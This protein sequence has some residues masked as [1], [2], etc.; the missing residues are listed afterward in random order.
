[1]PAGHRLVPARLLGAVEHAVHVGDINRVVVVHDDLADPAARQ[2]LHH[3]DADAA[4]ADDGDAEVAYALVVFDHPHGL[5]RHEPR[6]WLRTRS[7]GGGGPGGHGARGTGGEARTLVSVA[8]ALMTSIFW[9]R[10]LRGPVVLEY[11]R[12]T[13]WISFTWF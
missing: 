5:Q 11:M 1:M 3:A 10:T 13:S 6:V 8:S 2:H 12:T 9:R 7:R 4:D